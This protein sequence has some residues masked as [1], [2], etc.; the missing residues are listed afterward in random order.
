MAGLSFPDVNVWMTA[1]LV[2]HIHHSIVRSWW[3][4]DDSEA[5]CFT[6]ITQISVLRLLTT[7]A[8]MNGKPLTVKLAW[9]TYDR[10]FTDDRVSYM[11]EGDRGR[12]VVPA[13]RFGR[14]TFA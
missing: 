14:C 3:E 12:P 2:E 13:L 9:K 1:L 8:V 10:L 11:P 6:R 7:S 5:I 4:A